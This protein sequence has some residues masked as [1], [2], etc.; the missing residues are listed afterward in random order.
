MSKSSPK[1]VTKNPN[2][3]AAGQKTAELMRQRKAERE[4]QNVGISKPTSQLKEPWIRYAV[5]GTIIAAVILYKYLNKSRNT[6][7]HFPEPKIEVVQQNKQSNL[8][9]ME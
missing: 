6:L 8:F 5:G 7:E 4:A 3:V 2:R 9:Q 1:T